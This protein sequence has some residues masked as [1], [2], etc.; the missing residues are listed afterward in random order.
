MKAKI[1][2]VLILASLSFG[3]AVAQQ[4]QPR[5]DAALSQLRAARAELAKA[6]PDK[7]GHRVRAMHLLDKAIAEVEAGEAAGARAR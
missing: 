2:S 1:L 3:S 6:I 5:M 4:Q 7:A